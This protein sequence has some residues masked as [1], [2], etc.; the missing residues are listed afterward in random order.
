MNG[1]GKR[2]KTHQNLKQH[3]RSW[4]GN[5]SL[6]FKVSSK[7]SRCIHGKNTGWNTSKAT[8]QM[9]TTLFISESTTNV[10]HEHAKRGLRVLACYSQLKSSTARFTWFRRKAG[11]DKQYTHTHRAQ[12]I[13]SLCRFWVSNARPCTPRPFLSNHP[14]VSTVKIR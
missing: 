5:L 1:K 12:P 8:L 13:S 10:Q 9:D 7:P 11:S 4:V 2:K 14:A 6:F 3:R